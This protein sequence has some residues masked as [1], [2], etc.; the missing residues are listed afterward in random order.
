MHMLMMLPPRSACLRWAGAACLLML[1]LLV[2]CSSTPNSSA[3][4]HSDTG[5][6]SY[7]GNE[8]HGRKTANGE[9]FDQGK[10]TA[11]HRSLPFG[12]RVKVTNTQNGKTVVVRVNDRGPFV[13]GRII[14]LSSSAFRSIASLNAG[15]VPVRIQVM[16]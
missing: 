15:V 11:A 6:A 5:Q 1:A 12:T 13:K 9:R 16:D 14:D 10:L 2:G 8:F 3:S 7:Y 4:G